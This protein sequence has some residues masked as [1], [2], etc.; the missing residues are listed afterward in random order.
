LLSKAVAW[1]SRNYNDAM[2]F[3]SGLLHCF[4]VRND[5]WGSNEKIKFL[6]KYIN[7]LK[8]GK[9]SFVDLKWTCIFTATFRQKNVFGPARK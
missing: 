1:Q 6:K 4:A 8:F 7:L 5:E 3:F 9:N 2:G